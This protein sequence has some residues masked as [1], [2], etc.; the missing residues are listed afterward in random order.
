MVGI[1]PLDDLVAYTAWLGFHPAFFLLFL[2][3]E[4]SQVLT[5]FRDVLLVGEGD[6]YCWP[7]IRR[8]LIDKRT[9]RRFNAL[10]SS[11]AVNDDIAV[12]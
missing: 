2:L 1:S 10:D 4:V 7:L 11:I 8:T 6:R 5:A 9:K 3:F 12:F